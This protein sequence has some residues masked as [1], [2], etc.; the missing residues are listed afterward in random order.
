MIVAQAPCIVRV[1]IVR[2]SQCFLKNK[3]TY[4]S[5]QYLT[6]STWTGPYFNPGRALFCSGVSPSCQTIFGDVVSLLVFNLPERE[7]PSWWFTRTSVY[8]K[9]Y[10]TARCHLNNQHNPHCS[11]SC[12]DNK[13][14]C[15][16]TQKTEFR[17]IF[18]SVQTATGDEK[19][20]M[21]FFPTGM[22]H[23]VYVIPRDALI[24]LFQPQYR[25]L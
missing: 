24:Q 20:K 7:E 4:H 21:N 12:G 8:E 17:C 16:L 9:V 22:V 25:N 18:V 2:I 10:E 19:D 1:P 6:K 23:M 11:E 3:E 14:K 15:W 5:G 13:M